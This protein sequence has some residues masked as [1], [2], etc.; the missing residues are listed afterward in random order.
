MSWKERKIKNRRSTG[1]Y[2]NRSLKRRVRVG[3]GRVHPNFNRR[4]KTGGDTRHLPGADAS[5]ASCWKRRGER[6]A[7]GGERRK[8]FTP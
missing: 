3:N 7:G 5:Q 4:K 1:V 8:V 2:G 6:Q